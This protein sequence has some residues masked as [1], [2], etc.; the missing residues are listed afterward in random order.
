MIVPPGLSRPLRSAS[1]I[2]DD[3]DAVLHRAARI[4]VIGL[5]VHF[6]VQSRRCDS[7]E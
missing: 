3:A 4:Q 7:G 6:G 2:I 1:S 5:D